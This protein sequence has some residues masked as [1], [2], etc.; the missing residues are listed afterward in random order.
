MKKF[1]T[2]HLTRNCAAVLTG[3][4]LCSVCP[5]GNFASLVLPVYAAGS[6]Q[7]AGGTLQTIPATGPE[8]AVQIP[9]HNALK[10]QNGFLTDYYKVVY[11]GYFDISMS[12]DNVTNRDLRMYIPEG[13][14]YSQP[15]IYLMVPSKTD[16]YQFMVDSGW[17]AV[18]DKEKAT[19]YLLM[20]Q[21][22]KDG[23]GNASDW[24]TWESEEA[25]QTYI[26]K[27]VDTAG[28]RP[29]IQTVSYCFYGVGYG[30]GADHMTK[31]IMQN[32]SKMTGAFSVGSTG[33]GAE[34]IA[35]LQQKPSA[36]NGVMT[37]QVSVP[38]GLV[39]E[40]SNEG[41]EALIEYFKD[42][43]KTVETAAQT[44]GF[45]YYAPD[46][47][48]DTRYPDSEPVAGVYYQTASVQSCMNEAYAQGLF[49]IFEQV[50]RYPGFLN[51]ELRAYEDVYDYA[52]NNYEYYTS[53]TALG[54]CTYGGDIQSQGDGEWYNREWWLYVPDSAKERMNRGEKV[55]TLF[56]FMGSNGY[57]D[58]VPQRT[59]WDSVADENGFIIV[60]PSGHVRHQGNFGNFDRNGVDVYQY[61][62]NWRAEGA[63]AVLPDDLLMIDDIYWWLFNGSSYA[64]S[65][66][67]SRVY[68]SGQSAG[69]KF[70]HQVAK[71]RPQ[72]FAA[73]AP[74]SWVDSGED[75]DTSS[76]V[77][78]VVMMGQNDST[79][80]GALSTEEAQKMFAAYNSRYGGLADAAGRSAWSD[81]TF[82]Q[83]TQ[84]GQSVCTESSGKF[85][86]YI[87]RTPG[88]VPMFTGLEVIGL[89]HATVPTQCKFAWDTMKHFSKN[90]ETKAL[91][92]DGTAVD[93]PV[94][95]TK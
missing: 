31:Y 55:E 19:V 95:R 70:A 61:C 81:F 52:N 59:G 25:V 48:A 35:G 73:S 89:S 74:S 79:I 80:K 83:E 65:L 13:S 60:S 11:S 12:Y 6:L 24:G 90:P 39:A 66:D 33:A 40:A 46:V 23:A 47:N 72:Y 17:K 53:M 10:D 91:Y 36:E 77:A 42:A 57:G 4:M 56:L 49:D 29:G 37:S 7:E 78:M 28:Q 87:L 76:D 44:G 45:S 94:T 43:N 18:A 69:G 82:M 30:D 51:T 92:Y 16:P 3:A 27:A 86:K 26:A 63:T 54:R 34:L 9:F 1:K 15:T 88:G 22:V 62:T 32:P 84:G 50:R 38:F 85:N 14:R 5:A 71:Y 68:A 2:N 58:E 75:A 20:P 67:I 93:T 41:T 64:G 21:R 8:E